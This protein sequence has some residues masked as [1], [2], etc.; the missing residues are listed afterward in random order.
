MDP[1]RLMVLL[2]GAFFLAFGLA[3][4]RHFYIVLG[5]TAG[6]SI[7]MAV[8]DTMVLLPGLREHPG[9]AGLL[10][11]ALLVLTGGFFASRFRRLLVFAGGLGTGL[12][13]S[14]TVSV[15]MSEG[16]VSGAAFR[17]GRLDAMDVLV[18]LVGG[19]LFLLFERFFAV[20]LTS[21]VGSFLC[22]WA[23]GGR[24]TFA[25]CLVVG[26]VAQPLIFMRFNR[27]RPSSVK[28]RT[29]STMM[30]LL[31][32]IWLAPSVALAD[33]VV[34][35]TN[36]LTSRVVIGAGWRDGVREGEDYAIVDDL[37]SLVAV[38]T[39]GDVFST[40]QILPRSSCANISI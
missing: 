29:G 24:W 28:D 18:G 20:L 1:V 16:T 8:R 26:L 11:L 36:A 38:I 6:L 34:E 10:L 4:Y 14:Q 19:V 35:R 22:T 2:T 12:I 37:G 13:L 23:I 25:A 15:F 31:L 5:A 40:S 21:V 3:A 32:F 7:W 39:V 30:M 33:W 9:T 27:S 17:F